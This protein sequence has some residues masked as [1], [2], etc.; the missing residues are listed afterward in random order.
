MTRDVVNGPRSPVWAV[1]SRSCSFESSLASVR[2]QMR[3]MS[4]SRCCVISSRC[5]SAR[6]HDLGS[7]LPVARLPHEVRVLETQLH[8][9]VRYRRVDRAILATPSRLRALSRWHSSRRAAPLT[10]GTLET[11]VET[12]VQRRFPEPISAM[13]LDVSTKGL[14]YLDL[15]HIPAS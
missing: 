2:P 9:R 11:Q 14:K 7:P 13:N 10:P 6:W 1:Q 5:S 15:I 12:L 4:G 8:E 3:R